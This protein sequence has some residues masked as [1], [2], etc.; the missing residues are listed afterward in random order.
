MANNIE[1]QKVTLY[2]NGLNCSNCANK[3]SS[4]IEKDKRYENSSF[5]FITKKLTFFS[6][7]KIEKLIAE[8][9]TIVDSIESGVV[10]KTLRDGEENF[11]CEE[12]S[13]ET[14]NHSFFNKT[15]RIILNNL[16]LTFAFLLVVVMFILGHV[17]NLKVPLTVS[18]T[19]YIISYLLSGY[20]VLFAS[21]KNIRHG[22]IF[23][24]NFLMSI[25]TIGAIVLGE[26]VE[27][28]MVMALYE[29][30]EAFENYAV[31]KSR[32]NITGLL[33]IK[34]EFA[35]LVI[36]SKVTTVDPKSVNVGDILLVKAGEK[37]PLDGVIVEGDTYLDNKALTGESVPMFYEVGNEILSGSINTSK[38]IKIKVTKNYTN[39]TVYKILDLVEN[40]SSKKAPTEKFI[41]KFAKY[42]TPFVVIAALA[43]AIIPPL[44]SDGNFSMWVSRAFIFLVISCPCALVLSVPIG[45][46]AGLGSASKNG[47]LVKGGNYLDVINS[48]DVFMFDKTGTLTKGNFKVKESSQRALE[49]ASALEVYSSHPIAKA[50]TSHFEQNNKIISSKVSNLEEVSGKGIKA[51][52][53]GKVLLVGNESF[54]NYVDDEK[55]SGTSVYVNYDGNYIGRIIV[56]DEIKDDSK[57]L[58]DNLS[59]K[60]TVML[61]G[62]KESTGLTVSK[63]L[64]IKKVYTDLLP[65]DKLNIINEYQNKGKK[66]LFA[67]DG[68]N[69]AP[70]LAASSVGIAMGGIGSDAAV[71]A[72]DIVIMN[73]E[74]SKIITLRKI[75][76]KT[77][78]VVLQNIWFAL[79][80]KAIFLTLGALGYANMYM[81]VFADTGVALLC[82]LNSTVRLIDIQE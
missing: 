33:D 55:S 24:E 59:D 57:L 20:K 64:G 54:V 48:I 11:N 81:A 46:F 23:D 17:P 60:E 58:I 51:L 65:S 18:T 4:K 43:L 62:D 8:I 44:L 32:K 29:V 77:R 80:I 31:D 5:S 74:P 72:A 36:S 50:I 1:K 21:L 56:E 2:L 73:D 79:G 38:A 70:V 10:V 25:A 16:T 63:S 69:D 67:G 26:Y 30:G 34:S 41:T 19:I 61:T 68:I 12:E 52:Y 75:S 40:A 49:L 13:C 53:E 42:Y 71:E 3:I 35:N 9:Q 28:V 27:A 45:Y 47:I 82:V 15:K 39:S 78:K 66:V 76:K 22:H 37:V 6:N 7:E 14:K